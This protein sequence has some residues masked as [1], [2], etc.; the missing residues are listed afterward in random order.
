MHPDTTPSSRQDLQHPRFA[1]QYLKIAVA[2][3]RRGGSA[4]RRLLLEGLSG[5]V[6]EVGAGQGRNFPHYP[7]AVTELVALEP[8]DSLRAAA[9]RSAPAAPVPVTVVA[10]QACGL[11]VGTRTVDAV[12]FSLVLCSIADP[13]A[14]LAEAARVLRPGGQVRFYEHVRSRNR[15]GALLQ[16]TVAPLWR[17]VGGGC[18]PDR[19][20]EALVRSAGFTVQRLDRFGFSPTP[21]TPPLPHVVGTATAP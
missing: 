13:G 16:S 8:E 2:A 18:R 15:L 7:E 14:A 4:H 12:V 5:R 11:P 9:E 21:G 6:L 1:R 20:T 3:D 10:G 19:D 17:R